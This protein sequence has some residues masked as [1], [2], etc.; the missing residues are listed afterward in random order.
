MSPV[1]KLR[2][3]PHPFAIIFIGYL[4]SLS[5]LFTMALTFLTAYANPSYSTTVNINNYGEAHIEFILIPIVLSIV[6]IGLI[7]SYRLLFHEV[8]I[9]E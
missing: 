2:Y 8:E 7:K 9:K 5:G 6:V 1:K 3:R 4:L